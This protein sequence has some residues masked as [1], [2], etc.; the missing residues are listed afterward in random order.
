MRRR[1]RHFFAPRRRNRQVVARLEL[2]ERFLEGYGS[3]LNA[4]MDDIGAWH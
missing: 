1:I 4:M 3:M 2:I